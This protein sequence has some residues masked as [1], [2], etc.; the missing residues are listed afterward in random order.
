MLRTVHGV[1]NMEQ[2]N[3][4]ERLRHMENTQSVHNIRIDTVEDLINDHVKECRET[5]RELRAWLMGIL[6]TVIV[7]AILAFIRFG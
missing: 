1:T 3:I 4:D 6:G 7:A 2:S 5:R